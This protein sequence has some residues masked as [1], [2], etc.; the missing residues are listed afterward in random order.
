LP[1]TPGGGLYQNN[2]DLAAGFRRLGD[3]PEITYRI[4]FRP[5]GVTPDGSYHKLKVKSA[6][7]KRNFSM[8]ASPRYVAPNEKEETES[9]QAKIDLKSWQTIQ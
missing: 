7:A 6:H 9:L 4:S 5:D 1:R 8:Q 2:N 3:P